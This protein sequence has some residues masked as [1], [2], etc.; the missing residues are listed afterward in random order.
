MSGRNTK[1]VSVSGNELKVLIEDPDFLVAVNGFDVN[2]DVIVKI[3]TSQVD[4]E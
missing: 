1:P 3:S 4:D 2:R